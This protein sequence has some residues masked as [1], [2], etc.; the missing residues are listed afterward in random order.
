MALLVTIYCIFVFGASLAGGAAPAFVKI[1]H[2]RMQFV[3]SFVAGL[4]LGVAILH[5]LPHSL[6]EQGS[7]DRTAG[8]T[9][10]GL[11]TMFLLIRVFHFHVHEHGDTSDVLDPH[12]PPHAGACEHAHEHHDHA[13]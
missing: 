8:W 10:G 7:I 13:P 5:L 2:R 1:G 12:H 6:A 3:M 11:L 9:L 4:M